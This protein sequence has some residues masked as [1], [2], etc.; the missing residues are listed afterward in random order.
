MRQTRLYLPVQLSVGDTI[1]L[2]ERTR[3]HCG[4][5]LRAKINDA[6]YL[7]NGN[8][9]DYE[10]RLVSITKK[11][12]EA[13][14]VAEIDKPSESHLSTRLGQCLS[15]SQRFDLAIQ[16]ATEL[17]VSEITPLISDRC[18]N[19]NH[20]QI[21]K[22]WHHWQQIAIHACEQSHRSQIPVIEQ[23]RLL[24]DWLANQQ[25]DV[26]WLCSISENTLA[27]SAKAVTSVSLL[28]GPEG[29]L[30][31][32]EETEAKNSGFEALQ[33]GP[34]IMRTETAPVAALSLAQFLWGDFS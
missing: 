28:V 30:S 12:I 15:S 29:G 22:K 34:R 31:N 23:P 20:K 25:S 18:Q 2:D 14:L 3:H 8:G 19:I 5:V 7:F 33:L 26:K 4:T 10:A 6:V 21:E 16:K 11:S 13:E 24:K 27:T 17:G 32:E 9:K 1:Q